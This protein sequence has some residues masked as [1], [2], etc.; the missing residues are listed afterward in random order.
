MNE[1]HEILSELREIH[2]EISDLR[3]EVRNFFGLFE[4]DEREAKE[5]KEDVEAY[6]RGK[7]ET[8]SID[9]LKKDLNL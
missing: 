6:K 7:L 3:D 9:E 2:K 8:L 1:L 5:L 4:L